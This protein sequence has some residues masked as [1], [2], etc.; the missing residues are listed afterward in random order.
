MS[1]ETAIIMVVGV[2]A[3]SLLRLVL[4]HVGRDF[5]ADHVNAGKKHPVADTVYRQAGRNRHLMALPE[6]TPVPETPKPN[7]A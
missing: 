4:S 7:A 1:M 3:L 6:T 5:K 2:A